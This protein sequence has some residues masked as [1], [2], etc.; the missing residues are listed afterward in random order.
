[1]GNTPPKAKFTT[2]CSECGEYIVASRDD[3]EKLEQTNVWIHAAC[4]KDYY[5]ELRKKVEKI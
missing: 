1:M 2:R 3:I 4:Y 5:Q